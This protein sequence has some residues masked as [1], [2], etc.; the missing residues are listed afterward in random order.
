LTL[1]RCHDGSWI[2]GFFGL[3]STQYRSRLK[4]AELKDLK[5]QEIVKTRTRIAA[6]ITVYLGILSAFPSYGGSLVMSAVQARRLRV[7]HRKL[8]LIREEL[9]RRGVDLHE[10]RLRDVAIPVTGIAVGTGVGMGLEIGLGSFISAG[11]MFVGGPSAAAEDMDASFTERLHAILEHPDELYRGFS[12]GL[13]EEGDLLSIGA[14]GIDLHIADAGNLTSDTFVADPTSIDEMMAEVAGEQLGLAAAVALEKMAA[15][16]VSS[17]LTQ[18]ID[19]CRKGIDTGTYMRKCDKIID[20]RSKADSSHDRL[21]QM[22][23]R[24]FR[25]L[26]F[27]LQARQ[28][29]QVSRN[30]RSSSS[31]GLS[32][33]NAPF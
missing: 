12:A 21:L 30:F 27:V 20:I 32:S 1:R 7:A 15:D 6:G 8:A 13:H 11:D 18:W 22:R 17:Q 25:P 16:L 23:A 4:E 5:K 26:Q 19:G 31:P 14:H 10:L 24:R 3:S 28:T 29:V 2:G 9:E 33:W